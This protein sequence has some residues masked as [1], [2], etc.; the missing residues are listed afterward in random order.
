MG[1]GVD[2]LVDFLLERVAL[3]GEQGASLVDIKGFVQVFLTNQREATDT[4]V[5]EDDQTELSPP[6]IDRRFLEKV[7][8]W[9]TAHPDVLISPEG[10]G[11]ALTL[12]QV[13]ERINATTSNMTEGRGDL[14]AND[15]G[16]DKLHA[17][18]QV[19]VTQSRMWHAL[20]GHGVDWQ[21]IPRHEFQLLSI[22]AFHGPDG[23]LQRDLTH[24]SGQD[25]R[26]T[27]QRTDKLAEKGYITKKTVYGKGTKTSLCTLRRF[28]KALSE[29]PRS[30]YHNGILVAE[31]LLERACEMLKDV[32]AIILHDFIR[33]IL[34]D[35]TKR[36]RRNLCR[37]INRMSELGIVDIV[38][39]TARVGYAR[40]GAKK[41]LRCIKL[42][43]EPTD[44]DR[45]IF[46]K[47][48]RF[49][50]SER[51]GEK[52][53]DV[54]SDEEGD[55]IEDLL[56]DDEEPAETRETQLS[57]QPPLWTPDL[58]HTNQ[59]F[60]LV[61]NSGSGGI[62][63]M[64]LMKSGFGPFWVR[65][66]HNISAR[67]CDHWQISQPP[68][69]RHLG[70]IRDNGLT[71]TATNTHLHYVYR[72]YDNFKMAVEDGR[73]AWEAVMVA[74]G[75][76]KGK[77]VTK[78]AHLQP[79]M[80]DQWGFPIIA[81]GRILGHTNTATLQDLLKTAKVPPLK[82]NKTDPVV[83]HRRNGTFTVNWNPDS[84][85]IPKKRSAPSDDDINLD[86]IF[87][88]E[89]GPHTL[90]SRGLLVRP[91]K[92]D[93]SLSTAQKWKIKQHAIKE[94]KEWKARIL[95]K[96]KKIATAEAKEER[97]RNQ[98]LG[99][100]PETS[101]SESD[102]DMNPTING[103]A[104]RVSEHPRS[105]AHNQSVSA[106]LQTPILPIS[107]RDMSNS[108]DS[109]TLEI[110]Q[111]TSGVNRQ[112]TSI[113]STQSNMTTPVAGPPSST[114]SAV[115]GRDRKK[116]RIVD[117]DELLD[118]TIEGL[119]SFSTKFEPLLD[120]GVYIDPPGS[121][122]NRK[123]KGRPRKFM[124]AVFK[125][126][127]LMDLDWI[128]E[129]G[130]QRTLKK[131]QV[132]LKRDEQRRAEKAAQQLESNGMETT[133]T[134]N[135]LS[136]LCDGISRPLI[137]I[138]HPAT[139]AVPAEDTSTVITAH[140]HSE[141]LQ[142][143]TS[144]NHPPAETS[145][146]QGPSTT[147]VK[148]KKKPKKKRAR[149]NV[150][151]AR[152][153]ELV[154][155]LSDTSK[156]GLYINPPGSKRPFKQG[157]PRKSI[158]AVIKS[159][160][161]AKELNI[162]PDLPEPIY[163]LQILIESE[164]NSEAPLDVAT[165]G[166]AISE[167]SEGLTS[168][169]AGSTP[170]ANDTPS[171]LVADRTD[172]LNRAN[173]KLISSENVTQP[174]E[175]IPQERVLETLV[176]NNQT[177]NIIS[178][179]HV[180]QSKATSSPMETTFSCDAGVSSSEH[181][182]DAE[183]SQSNSLHERPLGPSPK[184]NSSKGIGILRGGSIAFNRTKVLNNILEKVDGVFPG[185]LR[186]LY[187]PL[188][189]E[190]AK[191]YPNLPKPDFYTISRHL[192]ALVSS[193]K[194]RKIVFTLKSKGGLVVTKEMFTTTNV[195]IDSPAIKD[196]QRKMTETFPDPYIPPIFAEFESE[197]RIA[198]HKKKIYPVDEEM[199][200]ERIGRP[201]D[202]VRLEQELA[203]ARI[204]RKAVKQMERWKAHE[205][206]LKRYH[207][208]PNNVPGNGRRPS[209]KPVQRLARISSHS[210]TLLPTERPLYTQITRHKEYPNYETVLTTSL[211]NPRSV[212][213]AT[214]GTY[215][216][217]FAFNIW[218]PRPTYSSDSV[219]TTS[220][221]HPL[222]VFCPTNGTYSTEFAFN[223]WI[224]RPSHVHVPAPVLPPISSNQTIDN[225]QQHTFINERFKPQVPVTELSEPVPG[226][227]VPVPNQRGKKRKA[228]AVSFET[229]QR[230]HKRLRLKTKKKPPTK[231]MNPDLQLTDADMRRLVMSIIV[232]RTLLGG[233][234]S[235]I[236]WSIIEQIFHTNFDHIAFRN[237]WT[238]IR[239]YF[240]EVVDSI[241]VAFQE[242]YLE[243]CESGELPLLNY[244]D[245]ANYQW[246]L[247]VD[248]A[249]ERFR[250]HMKLAAT[251]TL[252]S[253]LP[254]S[255]D[256]WTTLEL[257]KLLSS[258]ADPREELAKEITTTSRRAE[259]VLEMSF[260]TSLSPSDRKLSHKAQEDEM[261]I[262]TPQERITD[263][264]LAKSWIRANSL[265]P[266]DKYKPE[267]AREKLKSLSEDLLK[268]A[269][270][271]LKEQR[272]LRSENKGRLK[273]G[274]AF[275]I[276]DVYMLRFKKLIEP[277]A[278]LD[279][280][281]TK[282]ELDAIFKA[283]KLALSSS[284]TP[285]SQ[286]RT[287]VSPYSKPNTTYTIP[288]NASQGTILAITSLAAHNRIRVQP[289]LP[290]TNHEFG[291]P[292]PRLTRWGFTEGNYKTTQM[293]RRCVDWGM[294]VVPTDTYVYGNGLLASSEGEGRLS[295]PPKSYGGLCGKVEPLPLWVDVH[296]EV[297]LEW[298]HRLV[299]VVLGLIALRP[300][301]S[302]ER[303]LA[304]LKDAVSKAELRAALKWAVDVGAVEVVEGNEGGWRCREWWWMC[305]DGR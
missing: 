1:G 75:A 242:A 92:G 121:V 54:D 91:G 304:S 78:T 145:T 127:R 16:T 124:V 191:L 198:G 6:E 292:F 267:A 133:P 262:D 181:I 182:I 205:R 15:R 200:V 45:E 180:R 274:R 90:K 201:P 108:N 25:K 265:T 154:A 203:E 3:K 255:R 44:H 73:T 95:E 217:E 261:Q 20:T 287:Y 258:K 222:S 184:K 293:D 220:L 243:A 93:A 163:K 122:P 298:W 120:P 87:D 143:V 278:L 19:R 197:A 153:K 109:S 241:H 21:R 193:G 97:K 57:R 76:K 14:N 117:N 59:V 70:I 227:S 36:Q 170:P 168:G 23:I 8:K 169:K 172:T 218:V 260:S 216:T 240:P 41:L 102:K 268:A 281:K 279:A 58:P 183:N 247:V 56:K 236:N 239:K 60:R 223:T 13:E 67:I 266:A 238:W 289:K 297:M 128:A 294:E 140:P 94:Q 49:K 146:I 147:I 10:S 51:T 35:G 291:N 137:P 115:K 213:Y 164:D 225:P 50:P 301:I 178:S 26:S 204:R 177:A 39:A 174:F 82:L 135:G 235:A 175:A 42:L 100:I 5:S 134:D 55:D 101:D 123:I 161:I 88:S 228:L 199:I 215:S 129:G 303:M 142:Q 9:L 173:G 264:E 288:V 256:Q 232:V 132:R 64:D 149:L 245:I 69:L 202:A 210:H 253:Q 208:V 130:D 96:A 136:L 24:Q 72:S 188:S 192:K 226:L 80:V 159:N 189:A 53:I 295:H 167:E 118:R 99:L 43:R 113:I 104:D 272:V 252:G 106:T 219:L 160:R 79:A 151:Q 234:S 157:R 66:M 141:T 166:G 27:P 103:V 119:D 207:I 237:R 46:N 233:I 4:T 30:V 229:G 209:N 244:K 31:H 187:E 139:N 33:V 47:W 251:M 269:T 270:S 211:I 206:Q 305:L 12:V 52:Q 156:P 231:V 116:V 111:T 105:N 11:N 283:H 7:W 246:D 110:L 271:E 63:A 125:S 65:P 280:I 186:E 302:A 98:E 84:R 285:K 150:S 284:S 126:D 290:P 257:K 277:P 275:A 158:V 190:W 155:Q 138:D 254:A 144:G 28:H 38:L 196:A 37:A 230:P 249:T 176:V 61:E 214:N 194:I 250:E 29:Q 286:E 34:P 221:T 77:G 18:V 81:A 212:F 296:G 195:P 89:T 40:A 83:Q 62:T 263:L 2:D 148:V 85:A 17:S 48:F 71:K 68:H 162:P 22:I 185:G 74:S 32:N 282:H 276:N 112:N 131:R 107:G 259:I 248:W 171:T 300:G 224:T 299:G 152:I 114:V 86:A 179:R 165:P 273:P